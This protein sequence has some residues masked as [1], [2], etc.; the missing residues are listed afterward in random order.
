[1]FRFTKASRPKPDKANQPEDLLAAREQE[2]F[3][4]SVRA[5]RARAGARVAV[6]PVAD[7]PEPMAADS[8]IV[9]S[10]QADVY[11]PKRVNAHAYID[12]LG[13]GTTARIRLDQS[14]VLIR[15]SA[16]TIAA[17]H[18]RTDTTIE[19]GGL[20]SGEALFDAER[21]LFIVLVESALPAL[22]GEGT[23]TSFSYTPASWEAILPAWT[24]MRPEW[25]IVG[26][27]HSHPG[28]GV[29]LSS[30]DRSTQADVF[31]HDWQIAMVIDPVADQC[32]LFLGAFGL[33]C[34]FAVI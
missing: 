8:D 29:F 25:T 2:E 16:Y 27:Y 20:L 5:A 19:L 26:S 32:G 3:E 28:M 33:P 13:I 15:T 17:D 21:D 11:R 30:V 10:E 12:A 6:R 4:A 18:L 31:P 7:P 34:P 22:N 23:A 14:C 24:Q 9:W 1:M